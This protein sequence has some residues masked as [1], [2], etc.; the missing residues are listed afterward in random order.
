[1]ASW[2]RMKRETQMKMKMKM[3]KGRVKKTTTVGD[4]SSVE[5]PT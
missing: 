5:I 4:G 3:K 2:A 1:V